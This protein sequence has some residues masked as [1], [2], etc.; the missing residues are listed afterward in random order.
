MSPI[1]VRQF[2]KPFFVEPRVAIAGR[3]AI[4]GLEHRI[5]ARGEELGSQS[6]PHSSR[7]LGPPCGM[8]IAGRF[9]PLLPGGSVR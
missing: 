6:K 2:W 9:L 1:E 5:A 7:A 3:A 4:I 8:T